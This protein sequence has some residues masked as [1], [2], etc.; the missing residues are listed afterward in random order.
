MIATILI[1][2]LLAVGG[3]LAGLLI[4]MLAGR[5]ERHALQE[6]IDKLWSELDDSSK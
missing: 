6:E 2:A 3:F 4:G 1:Y 5:G